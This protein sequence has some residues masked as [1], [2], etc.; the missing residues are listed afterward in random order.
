MKL[1]VHRFLPFTRAEGP[2]T[3]ACVWVQGCSLRCAGCAVPWTWNP[4]GGFAR[5]TGELAAEIIRAPGIE[6]VTF[7]GGEPFDQAPALARLARALR[8]EG[9]SVVTFTGR[10][11][12]DIRSSGRPGFRDLL[13][14]TDLLIDGPFISEKA[15][16]SRPWVG[17]SNQHYHFLTGRYAHL[18]NRLSEFPNKFE[19][20]L[21]PDG[22]VTVNGMAA[23]GD[24]LEFVSALVD[25]KKA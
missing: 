21:S 6:G 3:R 7:L 23:T 9:L 11:I 2:G 13:D 18:E 1:R 8:A 16:I 15:G 5:D 19:V 22:R 25:N 10:L 4:A 12:E 14:N 17:S 20:R 24:L